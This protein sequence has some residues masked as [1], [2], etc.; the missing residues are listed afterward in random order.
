MKSR[1]WMNWMLIATLTVF[2]AAAALGLSGCS[3]RAEEAGAA[4]AET[5]QLVREAEGLQEGIR[6]GQR[7][8]SMS[9]RDKVGCEKIL[10]DIKVGLLRV[11]DRPRDVDSLRLLK[12]SLKDW[13]QIDGRLHRTDQSAF[14]GFISRVGNL[15]EAR[16]RSLGLSME[17]LSW[18]LF[19]S[20]FSGGL[21]P[22]ASVSTGANWETDWIQDEPLVKVSAQDVKA[23]LLSPRFDLKDVRDPAFRIEHLFVINRNTGRF[24]TDEFNRTKIMNE[25]FKVLVTTDEVGSDPAAASWER[26]DISPLPSAYNFHA[27]KSPLVSLEKY[28]GR[29][30]TLAFL[31]DMPTDKLGHHYLTWQINR[32]E[33]IGAGALPAFPERPKP[34]FLHKFDSAK[35]EPFVTTGPGPVNWEPFAPS[36]NQFKFAK[37]GSTGSAMESWLLSPRLALRGEKL[38]LR[39]K[40]TVRNPVWPRFRILI[41]DDYRSGDPASARWTELSRENP[42]AVPADSWTDLIAGPFDLSAWNKKDVVVAFQYTD[43]G[44]PGQRVWEIAEIGVEGTGAP[45]KFEKIEA[46]TPREPEPVPGEAEL[47]KFEFTTASLEPFVNFTPEGSAVRWTPFQVR[48][49]FKFAKAGSVEAPSEAWLLSPRLRASGPQLKLALRESVRNP[50]WNRWQ[51]KITTDPV[52]D[53]PRTA[54]WTV[55]ERT[56]PSPVAP[57]KWFD[58]A[59]PAIPLDSVRGRDFVIA[60]H[61]VDGG[62][63]GGRI[64]EIESL[65]FIGEGSVVLAPA[66]AAGNPVDTPAGGLPA[67]EPSTGGK[68]D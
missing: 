55:L 45:L 30:I 24:A 38:S 50:D 64:W 63:P 17:G 8:S 41:S 10:A 37:V 47:L 26:L 33:L 52:G 48:G 31:F 27:V 62:G 44:G 5:L 13:E 66:G 36:P 35:L 7:L 4:D 3:E 1:G 32:F 12:K 18:A 34:L 23:W 2:Q 16:S 40:E 42:A 25:A 56:P 9:A 15:L 61:Y 11:A 22:F 67:D 51:V 60:F 20:D 46:P 21:D 14:Q 49:Q 19:T 53:D 39:I 29:K 6:L 28:R 43:E 57:D 65:K 68:E 59:S 58:W 54:R